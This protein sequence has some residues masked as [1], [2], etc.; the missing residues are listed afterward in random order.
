MTLHHDQEPSVQRGP[1]TRRLRPLVLIVDDS[2]DI[3]QSVCRLLTPAAYTVVEAPEGRTG[4]QLL[5]SAPAPVVALLDLVMPVLDGAGM[6]RAVVDDPFLAAQHAFVLLTEGD[7]LLSPDLIGLLRWLGV[8]VLW[9]PFT[10]TA[11]LDAV[12][13][14]GLRL[15]PASRERADALPA[16]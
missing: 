6:L 11:L 10:P 12:A 7:R 4:L 9:K 1:S 8:G 5:R 16:L 2:L 13:H 3:R 15:A 14:A